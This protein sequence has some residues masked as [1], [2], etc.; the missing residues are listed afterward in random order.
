MRAPV[1]SG[2]S[3]RASLL[4]VGALGISA[5]MPG[6]STAKKKANSRCKKQVGQCQTSILSV[7]EGSNCPAA[8]A[9]CDLLKSCNFTN[10]VACAIAAT[11]DPNPV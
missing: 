3:K 2:L 7:C 9:C 8:I 5:L 10:F 4:S 11:N 1:L 6:V